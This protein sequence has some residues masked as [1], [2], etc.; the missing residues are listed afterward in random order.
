MYFGIY[1]KSTGLIDHYKEARSFLGIANY[2]K[3]LNRTNPD[4]YFQQPAIEMQ[5]KVKCHACQRPTDYPVTWKTKP[6]DI[7]CLVEKTKTPLNKLVIRGNDYLEAETRRQQCMREKLAYN[8]QA[9]RERT[10]CT[11]SKFIGKPGERRISKLKTET[12]LHKTFTDEKTGGMIERALV[13][14]TDDQSNVYK[15]NTGNTQI[16]P[17]S[18][19][20]V[21]GAWSTKNK[22]LHRIEPRMYE[23]YYLAFTVKAHTDYNGTKQTVIERVSAN[24]PKAKLKDIFKMFKEQ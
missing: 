8:M 2:I 23:P 13:I 3:G 22:T 19:P 20:D 12:I 14:F 1:D 16:I 5:Y 11:Q 24:I 15:W 18:D 21:P 10:G 6:Y 9:S 7:D 17:T 4:G